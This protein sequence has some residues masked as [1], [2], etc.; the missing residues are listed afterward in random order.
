MAYIFH[1]ESNVITLRRPEDTFVDTELI[2][3]YE[4]TRDDIF[5]FGHSDREAG[6]LLGC[7][8]KVVIHSIRHSSLL[9]VIDSVFCLFRNCDREN[10]PFDQVVIHIE[11]IRSF[12]H[13]LV[14]VYIRD[15]RVAALYII[16]VG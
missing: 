9:V 7:Q 15:G 11:M 8:E 16:S 14:S 13:H 5:I 10:R 2:A 1:V 12:Y 4:L 6:F 3:V